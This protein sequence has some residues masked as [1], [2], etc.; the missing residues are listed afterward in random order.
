VRKYTK[1]ILDGLVYLHDNDV[2]HLDIKGANI[3]VDDRGTIK[4]ADFGA[5]E[6]VNK[7][8][9]KES[10]GSSHI[11][12]SPYFMA[13]E[14]ILQKGY[15]NRADI[16]SVGAT[17]YQM[18]T[19][20]PPWKDMG[21]ESLLALMHHIRTHPDPPK[22]PNFL[23]PLLK[24]FLYTCFQ[25]DPKKR[26]SSRDLLKHPFLTLSHS[27]TINP[28]PERLFSVA[29]DAEL[30]WFDEGQEP[31]TE[32]RK[33]A[34]SHHGSFYSAFNSVGEVIA[35]AAKELPTVKGTRFFPRPS[36]LSIA[37]YGN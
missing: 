30:L 11:A 27:I 9:K 1:Q 13:P 32:D 4:L 14:V 35:T 37:F 36:D 3:L 33:A 10:G 24:S 26:V 15:D 6:K 20:S 19:G 22:I 29:E 7:N 28:P 23:S 16:W 34:I 25:R 2:I 5:S 21:F 18:A 8:V 31:D 17:V 12:G